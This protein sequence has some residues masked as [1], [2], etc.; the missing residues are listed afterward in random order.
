[1]NQGYIRL[2]SLLIILGL[3]LCLA[4]CAK[5]KKWAGF[6]E[7]DVPPESIEEEVVIDG[8]T[9]VKSRN[10][11]YLTYPDQPEYIYAEKGTEFYGMQDYLVKALAKE[12]AKEKK[13]AGAAVPPD[14]LQELVRQEVERVLREQGLGGMV[15]ASRVA[16]VTS[17]YPGRA[18]AVIPALS[19]TPSGYAGL[20]RTLAVSLATS[21]K[22]Q[23]ELLVVEDS[24]VKEAIG[25]VTPVGKL[26]TR[27]NIRALGDALG[28][29]GIVITRIVPPEKGTSGF[30]VLEL[31][32]TF[33]GNKVK[34]IVEPAGDA[35]LN[36]DTVTRFAQRDAYLMA[37]ELRTQ[38]WFGRVEFIQDDKVY[39]NLGLNTGLKVG[40]RLKVVEPGKEITNPVTH[41]SLGFTAD[42][43]LGELRV[44]EIIGNNAAAATIVSGG[45]FKPNDKVKAE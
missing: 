18:V 43:P 9:Y 30:M 8:K 31:Y 22:K 34:S 12:V 4:G 27:R 45:P 10:P 3:T 21:L 2:L 33:L 5:V 23:Q 37:G 28:V 24:Q 15:Y 19:E 29:Q 20:N 39:L 26:A 35:G 11:Y 13:K 1:M 36:M 42:T 6:P 7:E 38:D 16:G 25:K 14:K 32:D 44:A 40:D 17:A 41:A